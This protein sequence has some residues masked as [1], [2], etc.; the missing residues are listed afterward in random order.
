MWRV[1]RLA[2]TWLLALALPLQGLSAATMT[3]CGFGQH[4]HAPSHATSA[5]QHDETAAAPTHTH[6]PDASVHEGAVLDDNSQIDET[7]LDTGAG[8]KCSACA[9]CCTGATVPSEVL[10][11]DAVK[12]T[13]SFA[14]LDTRTI[15]AYVTEGLERPP[16]SVLA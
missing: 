8:Q 12:L 11:F 2:L 3:A 14:H 5:H 16:R 1:V 4:D 10:S 6:L 9:S 13:A 15:V 7:S